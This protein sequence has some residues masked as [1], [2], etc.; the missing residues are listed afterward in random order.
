MRYNNEISP[1]SGSDDRDAAIASFI[2][3]RNA[4]APE[5][6]APLDETPLQKN[7]RELAAESDRAKKVRPTHTSRLYPRSRIESSTGCAPYVVG[8]LAAAAIAF[9]SYQITDAGYG[10]EGATQTLEEAGYTG[11]DYEGKSSTLFDWR[12]GNGDTVAYRFT[13][14]SLNAETPTPDEDTQ[15]TSANSSRGVVQTEQVDLL[16]CKGVLKGATIRHL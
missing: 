12:C 6:P 3:R 16:V 13:A 2:Q 8:G 15:E 4:Q 5:R 14:D 11:I 1:S 9:G 10:E 7:L